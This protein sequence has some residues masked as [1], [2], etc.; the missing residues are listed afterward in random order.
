MSDSA[1][2]ARLAGDGFEGRL[3]TDNG[4][5]AHVEQLRALHRDTFSSDLADMTDTL[6]GTT[7]LV[8]QDDAYDSGA[9]RIYLLEAHGITT[10]DAERVD[11]RQVWTWRSTTAWSAA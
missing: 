2:L 9:R 11:A 1:I 5:E 7:D 6:I 10:F 8:T 4:P 3:I